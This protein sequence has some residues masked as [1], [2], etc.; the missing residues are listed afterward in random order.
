MKLISAIAALCIGL[1][2]TGCAH[3]VLKDD[4]TPA[5]K[6][7]KVFTRTI[8]GIGTIGFS[9]LKMSHYASAYDY[10]HG[11]IS[12][13]EWQSKMARNA[14]IV[15][16]VGAGLQVAGQVTQQQ[17]QQRQAQQPANAPMTRSVAR[18]ME[19]G[20]GLK[21]AGKVM[22]QQ[23][24]QSQATYAPQAVSNSGCTNDPACP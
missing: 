16:A 9:E 19:I 23:A 11:R 1:T 13:D 7:G 10:E 22:Q 6:T 2:L 15:N 20:A 5:E 12:M 14:A 3:L 24:Q 18:D 21:Q 8:L 17:A 4:D